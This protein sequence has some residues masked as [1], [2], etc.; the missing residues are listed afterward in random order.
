M[1]QAFRSV[2]SLF[3]IVVICTGILLSGC[4]NPGAIGEGV[5]ETG[6][7]VVVDTFQVGSVQSTEFDW[8]SGDFSF[9]SAGQVIDPIFGT[10]RAT[11]MLK[12][13]LPSASDTMQ[14]GAEMDLRLIMKGSNTYGDSLAAQSFDIYEIQELWRGRAWM[15]QDEV[16][17]ADTP[18]ASFTTSNPELGDPDSLDVPLNGQWLEEYRE[19]A[20]DAGSNADSLY[21]YEEFGLALVPTNSNKIIGIN[22]RSTR[23]I[24]RNP[25]ADTFSVP[26]S[27]WAYS[28]SRSNVGTIPPNSVPLHSTMESVVTA[29]LDISGAASGIGISRAELVFYEN[30]EALGSMDRNNN[31]SALLYLADPEGVPENIGLGNPVAQGSYNEADHSYRFDVT[32]IMRSILAN[33]MPEGQQFY[34][35][36]S[37]PGIVKST[38]LYTEDAPDGRAP[39]IIITSLKSSDS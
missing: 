39:K 21:Q 36:L 9:F 6:A 5:P 2:R 27:Q 8:Y 29:D 12:P 11:G 16:E 19:D 28:L 35:T 37:N 20:I 22:S 10:I 30:R 4:D 23:F 13:A 18:I 26:L 25:E 34:I 33:G 32:S 17:L 14:A 15:L 24:I 7:R 1:C 31:T 38:L 3:S